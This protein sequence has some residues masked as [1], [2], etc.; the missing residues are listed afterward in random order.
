MLDGLVG[1]GRSASPHALV[2]SGLSR[3]GIVSL[4]A[5]SDSVVGKQVRSG[6]R[7]SSWDVPILA[8]R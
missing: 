5:V 1:G 6:T 3:G 2:R 7:S 8:G 4:V